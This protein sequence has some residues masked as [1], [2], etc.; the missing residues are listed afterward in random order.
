PEVVGHFD[1][2]RIFH[3]YDDGVADPLCESDEVRRLAVRNIEY[4]IGYGAIFEINT[5]AWKKGLRDA[6]PQRDMLGEILERGGRVTIS[7]DSHGPGDVCMHYSRLLGYLREMG[8]DRLHYLSR[9][10]GASEGSSSGSRVCVLEK[11]S[12]HEF[13]AANGIA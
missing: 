6:Y 12:E 3:P 13:W 11:A 5:R 1:L 2:V 7:D 10:G 9:G 8:V 4:A